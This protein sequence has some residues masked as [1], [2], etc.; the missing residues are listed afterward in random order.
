M[1]F[2]KKIYSI[3][4]KN[5]KEQIQFLEDKNP[6]K[7]I[8]LISISERGIEILENSNIKLKDSNMIKSLIEL[9]D[10]VQQKLEQ[11]ALELK[12]D[13]YTVKIRKDLSKIYSY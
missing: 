10:L 5:F 9:N 6:E 2:E 12:K 13:Y 1:N 3:L 8:E 7:A 4:E 11:E